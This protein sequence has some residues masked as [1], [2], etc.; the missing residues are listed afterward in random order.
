MLLFFSYV[1]LKSIT[2]T[3]PVFVFLDE[4]GWR[5][6]KYA[7]E[8]SHEHLP[9]RLPDRWPYGQREGAFGGNDRRRE[10]L[11]SPVAQGPAP[12]SQ[13]TQNRPWTSQGTHQPHQEDVSLSP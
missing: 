1:F 6:S 9:R 13:R 3:D 10:G 5:W 8:S 11:E 7:E 2:F 4:N 12:V